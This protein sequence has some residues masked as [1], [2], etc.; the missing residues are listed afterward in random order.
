M[1]ALLPIRLESGTPGEPMN[2][3]FKLL[4]AGV[5]GLAVAASCFTSPA[6]AFK[7]HAVGGWARPTFT[8]SLRGPSTPNVNLGNRYTNNVVRTQRNSPTLNHFANRAPTNRFYAVNVQQ[9]LA[10][11]RIAAQQQ[12]FAGQQQQF[13]A[14][15]DQKMREKMREEWR[16][17]SLNNSMG[18]NMPGSPM[19]TWNTALNPC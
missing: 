6:Y 10:K 16:Q 3:S 1:N 13:R 5:V 17:R 15:Q 2:R 14:Q 7:Y 18:C 9:S 8:G 4:S 19:S 12:Q 11:G